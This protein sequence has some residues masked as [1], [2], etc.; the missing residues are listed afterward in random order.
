[1]YLIQSGNELKFE[2]PPPPFFLSFVLCPFHNNLLSLFRSDSRLCTIIGPPIS[3][4][5]TFFFPEDNLFENKQTKYMYNHPQS[6]REETK[7]KL[8]KTEW[9]SEHLEPN[10]ITIT[11]I[12][13]ALVNSTIF[14]SLGFF[15]WASC[16]HFLYQSS[17]FKIIL[18]KTERCNLKSKKHQK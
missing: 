4:S 11:N 16:L 5:T 2:P 13:V 1:M 7:T 17:C 8:N 3:I 18:D 12:F 15:E 9:P 14:Q 6:D 10:L